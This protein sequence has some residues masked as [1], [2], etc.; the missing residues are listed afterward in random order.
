MSNK[1]VLIYINSPKSAEIMAKTIHFACEYNIKKTNL[2]ISAVY[3]PPPF[4]A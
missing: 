2:F 1:S 4:F 3:G